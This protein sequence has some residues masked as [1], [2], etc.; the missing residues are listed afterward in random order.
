MKMFYT[1]LCDK[2][3]YPVKY[4]DPQ[5]WRVKR[6]GNTFG[7]PG[8]ASQEFQAGVGGEQSWYLEPAQFQA[9]ARAIAE[10]RREKSRMK[11]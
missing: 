1:V 10:L 7:D 5:T 11:G 2:P 8:E 6:F 3:G 9:K 4:I